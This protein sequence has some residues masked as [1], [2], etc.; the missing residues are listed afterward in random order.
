ME[1][2]EALRLDLFEPLLADWLKA[3]GLGENGRAV[4]AQVTRL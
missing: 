3:H 2:V 1:A 4:I